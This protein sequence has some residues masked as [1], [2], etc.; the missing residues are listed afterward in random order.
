VPTVKETTWWVDTG[1]FT[2]VVF[3]GKGKGV[4]GEQI[5]MIMCVYV[6]VE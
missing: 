4:I 6:D 3:C 1:V 2:G 5:M